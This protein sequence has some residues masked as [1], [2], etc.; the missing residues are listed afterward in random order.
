M[1]IISNMFKISLLAGAM[2]SIQ[3]AELNTLQ[4]ISY[5]EKEGQ[6]RLVLDFANQQAAKD[7]HLNP[8]GKELLINIDNVSYNMLNDTF[9]TD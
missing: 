9:N 7:F 6:F 5:S 1:K 8:Q 3:A 2:T 4:N